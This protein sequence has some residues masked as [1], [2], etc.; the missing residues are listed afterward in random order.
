MTDYELI[1][2]ALR[3]HGGRTVLFEATHV[4]TGIRARYRVGEH[5]NVGE[6]WLMM[7]VD[8]KLPPCVPHIKLKELVVLKPQA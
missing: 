1:K 4:S 2:A 6:G 7:G 8:E 5:L 3:E